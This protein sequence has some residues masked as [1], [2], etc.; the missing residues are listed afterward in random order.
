MSHGLVIPRN[1]RC[2]KKMGLLTTLTLRSASWT[3]IRRP[4]QHDDGTVRIFPQITAATTNATNHSAT[5][6]HGSS[7]DGFNHSLL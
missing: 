3:V 6:G 2:Y 7:D 5:A 1:K 4:M